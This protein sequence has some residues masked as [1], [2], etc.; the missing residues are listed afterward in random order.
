MICDIAQKKWVISF[1]LCIFIDINH[2]AIFLQKKM[3]L[4]TFIFLVYY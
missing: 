3:R 2:K 4:C 1:F